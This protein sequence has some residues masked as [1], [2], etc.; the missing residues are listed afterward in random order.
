M[1]SFAN[2]LMHSSLKIYT[3]TGDKGTSL[4]FTG[5]R[6]SKNNL[7]FHSLGSIDELNAYLGLA[8]EHYGS[9]VRNE[10]KVE[11]DDHSA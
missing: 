9:L 6:L 4:L 10:V 3:K 8:R 5:E 11:L 2:K 1:I 7:V